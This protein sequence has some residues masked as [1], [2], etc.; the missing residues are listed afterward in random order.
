MKN[1]NAK[2]ERK[3]LNKKLIK[4]TFFSELKNQRK[5]E[6]LI[7]IC[8]FIAIVIVSF[9]SEYLIELF[10]VNN[11]A[12]LIIMIATLFIIMFINSV[13]VNILKKFKNKIKKVRLHLKAKK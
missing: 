7:I 6:P 8:D 9:L 10:A 4:N 13:S 2:Q 12:K 5:I 1:K 3:A 11:I